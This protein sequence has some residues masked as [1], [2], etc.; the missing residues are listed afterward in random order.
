MAAADEPGQV[1][2]Q[3]VSRIL[4]GEGRKGPSKTSPKREERSF[5]SDADDSFSAREQR[6]TSRCPPFYTC[7]K[8]ASFGVHLPEL[9]KPTDHPAENDTTCKKKRGLNAMVRRPGNAFDP[10]AR[11]PITACSRVL[12]HLTASQPAPR[13]ITAR[14]RV[15]ISAHSFLKLSI[16]QEISLEA[17]PGANFGLG[18]CSVSRRSKGDIV[19]C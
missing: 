10:V 16:V 17:G 18:P 9:E 14:Y 1:Q 8:D 2:Y 7:P 13:H 11:A 15:P 5:L 12:H 3:T 6:H 19:P 4:Q